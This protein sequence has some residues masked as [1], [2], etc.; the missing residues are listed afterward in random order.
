MPWYPGHYLLP[1]ELGHLGNI[2]QMITIYNFDF[3]RQI[4][5]ETFL[6]Y[7]SKSL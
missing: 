7:I 4:P 5:M 6:G 2:Y 1:L 3:S